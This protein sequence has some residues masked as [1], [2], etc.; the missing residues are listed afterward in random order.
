MGR[1]VESDKNED[2]PRLL[3]RCATAALEACDVE[4]ELTRDAEGH[5]GARFNLLAD[6]VLAEVDARR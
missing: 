6:A 1:A 5:L 4:L 3:D 2:Y